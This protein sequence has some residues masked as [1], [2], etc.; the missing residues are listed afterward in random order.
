MKSKTNIEIKNPIF[1]KMHSFQKILQQHMNKN[2]LAQKQQDS[3]FF[4]PEIK[5]QICKIFEFLLNYRFEFNLG[6]AMGYFNEIFLDK[7]KEKN[8]LEK[9]KEILDKIVE[10]F[11][12]D[13]CEISGTN[14]KILKKNSFSFFRNNF[15][16]SFD[17][18][19]NKPFIECLLISFYFNLNNKE[20]ENSIINL[21]IKFCSQK[22]N[23]RDLFGRIELLVNNEDKTL[24]H[25]MNQIIK[26]LIENA[27]K[28]Q[29]HNF[30]NINI[31]IY[32]INIFNFN[33]LF[34]IYC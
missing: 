33:L 7:N 2:F 18:I 16:K 29:V 22:E 3:K 26:S 25:S 17:E 11:P 28:I 20:L 13:V 6:N 9:K 34:L 30:I 27:F 15:A 1:N 5:L 4:Y 8:F 19:I 24:Y 10:I 14:A 32:I 31:Y 23:F 12:A 21:I